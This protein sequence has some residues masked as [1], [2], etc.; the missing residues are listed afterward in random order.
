MLTFDAG[1]LCVKLGVADALVEGRNEVLLH[2]LFPYREL[3]L[4]PLDKVFLATALAVLLV[5]AVTL[6]DTVA[7][8]QVVQSTTIASVDIRP[9]RM[10]VQN[11]AGAL[12]SR[13]V[14]IQ[15]RGFFH[16]TL[17]IQPS[18]GVVDRAE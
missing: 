15:G 11:I 7:R 13:R 17:Q 1:E 18:L 2:I 8:V 3:F 9:G 5:Q 16:D 4:D 6:L 10:Q 14:R 12:E